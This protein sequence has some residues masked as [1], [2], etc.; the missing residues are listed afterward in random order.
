MFRAIGFAT[1]LALFSV[2]AQTA[3]AERCRA[4]VN[5]DEVVVESENFPTFADNVGAREKLLAWPSRTWN[6]AWGTPAACDSG[7]LF[8]YLATTVPTEEIDGYCLAPA[9]AGFVLVPG[10]RNFR[11]QCKKTVCE[12]VNTT[13]DETTDLTRTLAKSALETATQPENLST[14]AH[15]SGAFIL[16]GTAGTVAANLSTAGT[17]L[18]AALSTPAAIAAV[19]VSVVA[20]GGTVYM[21]SR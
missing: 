14:V 10:E 6:K 11:G 7:V 13:V 20:V 1:L 3:E 9:E 18:L 5:G 12:R 2:S 15:K 17:T 8:D 16:S 19:G 21:C 4:Y